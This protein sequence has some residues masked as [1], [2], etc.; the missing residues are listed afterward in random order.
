MAL[1]LVA[2]V[3][4]SNANS[5]ATV[6]EA[7]TEAEGRHPPP[8]A[9]MDEDPAVQAACLVTATQLL[10]QLA[11]VGSRVDTVQALAWPRSGA[12]IP[13]GWGTFATTV[14]PPALVRAACLLAFWLASQAAEDEDLALAAGLSSISL[15]GEVS[16]TFEPGATSVTPVQRVMQQ[17][18]LPGLRG[19]VYATQSRLVRG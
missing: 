15:G 7:L 19:L 5:Y 4:A 12:R 3:G 2:T 6:A 10:D 16:L 18:I 9:F 1:T 17:E 11:W 14:L 8:T 13:D